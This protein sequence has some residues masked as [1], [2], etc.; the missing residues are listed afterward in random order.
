MVAFRN[1]DPESMGQE[2]M[3]GFLSVRQLD[4][5]VHLLDMTSVCR[6]DFPPKPTLDAECQAGRPWVPFLTVFGITRPGI[7]PRSSGCRGALY[8]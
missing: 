6:K 1:G 5:Q 4:V 2:P 3:S 8:H 7:E